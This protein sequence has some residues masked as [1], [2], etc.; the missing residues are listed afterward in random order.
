[1]KPTLMQRKKAGEEGWKKTGGETDMR[2]RVS[3]SQRQRRSTTVPL[4]GRK[5]VHLCTRT[6]IL[7]MT[8]PFAFYCK[9]PQ[10]HLWDV[11]M[12]IYIKKCTCHDWGWF[13]GDQID[14]H[15]PSLDLWKLL[16]TYLFF[17][18]P[19]YYSAILLFIKKHTCN[20]AYYQQEVSDSTCRRAS[21]EDTLKKEASAHAVLLPN[22]K[23]TF[24]WTR[25]TASVRRKWDWGCHKS[26]KCKMYF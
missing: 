14:N 25:S 24:W 18:L 26:I 11:S 10:D 8:A 9:S 5:I 3:V 20:T 19:H 2:Q 13:Q 21:K 17:Q 4:F 6:S 1:M 16:G 15:T 12:Y 23:I 7:D 22:Q